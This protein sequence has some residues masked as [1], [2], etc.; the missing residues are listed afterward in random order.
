[1]AISDRKQ[2]ASSMLQI[3]PAAWWRGRAD[4]C[5]RWCALQAVRPHL[6]QLD[7]LR[8]VGEH[9]DVRPAARM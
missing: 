4:G 2:P 5:A 6:T 9:L 7:M 1:V 8:M 3:L